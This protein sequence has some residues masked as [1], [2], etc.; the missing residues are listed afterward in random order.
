[1][2]RESLT[3]FEYQ[4]LMCTRIRLRLLCSGIWRSDLYDRE[5][6]IMW[7]RKAMCIQLRK[8]GELLI[9]VAYG[10]WLFQGT[11]GTAEHAV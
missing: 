8:I 10:S 3:K 11:L 5:Q 6:S 7:L 9:M 1:M 2:L 4:V